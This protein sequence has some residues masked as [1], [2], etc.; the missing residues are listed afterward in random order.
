MLSIFFSRQNELE[1]VN[2]SNNQKQVTHV[3]PVFE[4]L[5][6]SPSFEKIKSVELSG[7]EWSLQEAKDSLFPILKDA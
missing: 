3:S 5:R 4:A 6:D 2:L 1:A 7:V